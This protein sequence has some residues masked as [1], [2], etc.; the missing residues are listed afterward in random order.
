M[1]I[2]RT[3]CTLTCF[4]RPIKWQSQ[5]SSLPSRQ[6]DIPYSAPLPINSQKTARQSSNNRSTTSLPSLRPHP[7]T[8]QTA[9]NLE[10]QSSIVLS[11]STLFLAKIGTRAKSRNSGKGCSNTTLNIDWTKLTYNTQTLRKQCCC[12]NPT[13]SSVSRRRKSCRKQRR[14]T[15]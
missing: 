2:V 1:G 3:K 15:I 12:S 9:K 14:S 6:S 13:A 4:R 5:K 11:P 10:A 8:S 7:A